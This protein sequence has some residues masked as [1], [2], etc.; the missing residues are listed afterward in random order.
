MPLVAAAKLGVGVTFSTSHAFFLSQTT[1]EAAV[2]PACFPAR[3]EI[4]YEKR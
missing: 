4:D 2:L 3:L 1:K